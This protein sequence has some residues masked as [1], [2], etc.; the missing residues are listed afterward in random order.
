MERRD[1]QE[2][3]EAIRKV[4]REEIWSNQHREDHLFLRKARPFIE[5]W[6]EFVDTSKNTIVRAFWTAVVGGVFALLTIGFIVWLSTHG[7][8]GK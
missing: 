4:V 2:I 3:E 7:G 8:V 6:I 5:N 1:L